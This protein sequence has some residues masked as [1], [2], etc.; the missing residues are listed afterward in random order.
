MAFENTEL[1]GY[2]TEKLPAAFFAG[3]RGVGV[4]ERKHA[5]SKGVNC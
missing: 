4:D 5:R 2:V 1:S 3:E